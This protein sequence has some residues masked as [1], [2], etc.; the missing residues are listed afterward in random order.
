[1]GSNINVPYEIIK[2]NK[3]NEFLELESKHMELDEKLW[4]LSNKQVEL[5]QS[6]KEI[7][8]PKNKYGHDIA[9]NYE[10]FKKR[11]A[12]R[13]A[14]NLQDII[15]EVVDNEGTIQELNAEYIT[16]REKLRV[17]YRKCGLHDTV[18]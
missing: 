1:M 16:V 2:N 18:I 10:Y 4:E 9:Y 13:E 7:V 14:L 5:F 11:K 3:T 8:A 17:I 15:K 12:W 6:L